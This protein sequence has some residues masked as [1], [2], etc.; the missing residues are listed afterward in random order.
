MELTAPR[1]ILLDLDDT[2]LA[3]EA[4]KEKCWNNVAVTYTSS[5]GGVPPADFVR[6]VLKHSEWFWSDAAR[7]REWRQDLSAAR[8]KI[9]AMAMKGL[10]IF[11]EAAC[12]SI[13][14]TYSK[15]RTEMIEPIPGAIDTL[16]TLKGK[17]MRTALITNG[18]SESQRQKIERFGLEKHFDEILIEG[19]QGY[20]KPDERIYRKALSSLGVE[21]EESWMV[22]DNIVWDVLAPQKLGVRG[23]WVDYRKQGFRSRNGNRP[24]LSIHTLPEIIGH[25][26]RAKI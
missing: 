17:G 14:S 13:A 8:L 11:N 26:D 19:E 7:G 5:L 23:V 10:G 15:M 18:S 12:E 16:V 1:A 4:L 21:A 20:G 3:F 25:L 9:L 6:T 22:G 2:I 24:F